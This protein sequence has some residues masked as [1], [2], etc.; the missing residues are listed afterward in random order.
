[1]DRLIR[2][3]LPHA[4]RFGLYCSP[5]IPAEKVEAARRAYASHVAASRVVALYDATLFGSARDGVLFLP[6]RLVYQNNP[7]S[8]PQTIPYADIVDVEV[9]RMVLGGRKLVVQVTEASATVSHELDFS[10]HREA[11]D[12][13]ARLLGELMLQ[14]PSPGTGGRPHT[15]H[16]AVRAALQHLVETGRLTDADRRRMLDALDRD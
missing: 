14:P 9:R 13:V 11:A 3:V 2:E 16:A 8:P 15:D 1:M 10:A 12:A 5:D 6:D 7:V 4:P